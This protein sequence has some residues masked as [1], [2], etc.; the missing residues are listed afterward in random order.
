MTRFSSDILLPFSNSNDLNSCDMLSGNESNEV[1][2]EPVTENTE[3]KHKTKFNHIFT[4][5]ERFRDNYQ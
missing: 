5:P 2:A 4:K 3:I 1:D